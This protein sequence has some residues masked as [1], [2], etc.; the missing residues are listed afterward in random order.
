MQVFFTIYI[1]SKYQIYT[2]QYSTTRLHQQ[3]IEYKIVITVIFLVD[4]FTKNADV[5]FID[6]GFQFSKCIKEVQL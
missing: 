1:T 2:L 3:S 6:K 5:F 4:A